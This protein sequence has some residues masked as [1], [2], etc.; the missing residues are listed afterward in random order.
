VESGDYDHLVKSPEKFA[1]N[2]MAITGDAELLQ[3]WLEIKQRWGIHIAP[4]SRGVIRRRL[5]QERNLR[6]DWRFDWQD[7][8]KKFELF[9]DAMCYRWKLYGMEQDKPLLLKVSVNP[10]PHGTMI[11][12]P[13]HLS[14]DPKRDLHWKKINA[15]HRAQGAARQG[16]KLSQNRIDK[17]KDARRVSQ[18]WVEAKAKGQTGDERYDYV[19][20]KMGKPLTTDQSWVKRHL[21][22]TRKLSLK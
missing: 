16:R 7:E 1:E 3:T 5:S 20:K 12:I 19:H 21:R 9:F 11:F 8:K 15:L 10:T 2:D 14:L 6:G 22:I 17:I 13:R 18:L 4:N